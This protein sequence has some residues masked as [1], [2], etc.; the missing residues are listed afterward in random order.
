MMIREATA[1]LIKLT[2]WLTLEAGRILALL[3][4]DPSGSALG[5]FG[6]YLLERFGSAGGALVLTGAIAAWTAVPLL[7]ARR[8]LRRRPI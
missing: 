5:P 3:A 1:R 4:A 8:W 6:S 2:A 7:V